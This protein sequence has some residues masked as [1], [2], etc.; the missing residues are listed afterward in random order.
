MYVQIECVGVEDEK[1]AK[2]LLQLM[3]SDE[4]SVCWVC[5]SHVKKH[6]Q[7]ILRIIT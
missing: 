1:D 3:D 2:D 6:N 4:E 5:D 7:N